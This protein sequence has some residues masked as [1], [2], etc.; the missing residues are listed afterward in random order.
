MSDLLLFLRFVNVGLATVIVVLAGYQAWRMWPMLAPDVRLKML[1]LILFAFA[2]GYGSVE[3]QV[4]GVA[5]APRV[6][7]T[8]AACLWGAIAVMLPSRFRQ[9]Y[10]NVPPERGR[11]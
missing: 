10:T 1:A 9:K 5:P 11:R 4:Q 3:S 2:S 6:I 7:F 8:F